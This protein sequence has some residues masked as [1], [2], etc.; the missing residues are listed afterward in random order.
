MSRSKHL[1]PLPVLDAYGGDANQ[2]AAT[3]ARK[4]H[5]QWNLREMLPSEKVASYNRKK[6][7]MEHMK[8]LTVSEVRMQLC[9]TIVEVANGSS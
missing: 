4:M 6:S 8:M 9:H 2:G 3:A 5:R 7:P 1:D